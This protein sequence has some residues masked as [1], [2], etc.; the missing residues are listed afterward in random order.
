MGPGYEVARAR[1]RRARAHLC[2]FSSEWVGIRRGSVRAGRRW[3]DDRVNERLFPGKHFI[4]TVMEALDTKQQMSGEMARRYL[5][6]AAMA[7]M[8]I[9]LMYLTNFAV[10]GMFSELKLG[11]TALTAG[12][13][14]IARDDTASSRWAAPSARLSRRGKAR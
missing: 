13:G 14:V 10:V 4:S 5:Q 6:R 8:I 9:G 11:D 12:E 7:G 1:R 3:D 2:P